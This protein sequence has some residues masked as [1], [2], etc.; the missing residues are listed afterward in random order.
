MN[1]LTRTL[2]GVGTA[3]AVFA[4]SYLVVQAVR[5]DE[6]PADTPLAIPAST[7]QQ[8]QV[9]RPVSFGDPVESADDDA[10]A[11]PSAV[12]GTA[13][14]T[15]PEEAL[16]PGEPTPEILAA[17]AAL[18]SNLGVTTPSVPDTDPSATPSAAPEP[19]SSEPATP[20]SDP[21]AT[22]DDE[23]CPDGAT[24]TLFADTMGD[25][26][27]VWATAD[28]VTMAGMGQSIYCPDVATEEGA[29]RLG[30][31]TT[32]PAAVTITYWPQSD[33]TAIREVFMDET[34]NYG[35]DGAGQCG[36]TGVLE[37]GDY[38]ATAI[39]I[40]AD[41]EISPISTFS[42]DYRGRPIEPPMRVVPLGTN[43]LWVGVGHG[44]YQTALIETVPLTD[45]ETGSCA[46]VD[47]GYVAVHSAARRYHS[48]AASPQAMENLN[49]APEFNR[50]T[51]RLFYIPEGTSVGVCGLTLNDVDTPWDLFAADR[52]QY[53]T[54]AAPDALTAIVSVRTVATFHGGTATFTATGQTGAGCG[55]PMQVT[56]AEPAEVRGHTRTIFDQ[57]IC[58]IS[59]QN[60][61][62]VV[63]T[64]YQ[65]EGTAAEGRSGATF[66]VNSHNCTGTCTPP[67]ME[68][69]LVRLPGLGLDECAA[70]DSDCD[71]RRVLNA[72]A[73][74]DVNWVAEGDGAREAWGIGGTSETRP[75]DAVPER[76]QVD[77]E[78]VTAAFGT[79][80]FDAVASTTIKF[81]RKVDYT[82]DAI[83]SCFTNGA[84]S[85]RK[86]GT[87]SVASGGVSIASIR[88]EGLC[89][90][91]RYT[92]VLRATDADGH[93]VIVAH[94]GT[95]GVSQDVDWWEETVMPQRHINVTSTITVEKLRYPTATWLVD[96]PEV[97]IDGVR[98]NSRYDDGWAI[99]LPPSTRSA[100]TNP[101]SNL[102]P[103][104]REYAADPVI[105][106][107]SDIFTVPATSCR[108]GSQSTWR[109]QDPAQVI[110][111][112]VLLGGTTLTGFVTYQGTDRSGAY[113]NETFRY[114][115]HLRGELVD[116]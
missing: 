60:V 50:M 115:I 98:V 14:V 45:G 95:P 5:S 57:E 104:T 59:G 97:Q 15:V 29:L 32:E 74:V 110:P 35:D 24:V 66:Y 77:L 100:S 85:S 36:V 4:T 54:A 112:S 94:P 40:S 65:D 21:C 82:I 6:I 17:A 81:D 22:G 19:S 49:V 56:I 7:V 33:P 11:Q 103:V 12:V 39:A 42:F 44:A 114:T 96:T 46:S 8:A 102:V 70:D 62:L 64:T 92:Y 55:T 30:S 111:H 51:S 113:I 83:G 26:L 107:H 61:R 72:T 99:C 37:E 63:N 47:T 23:A 53:A 69:Y 16:E 20:A 2:I 108:F 78:P 106:V 84:T 101:G 86:S 91:S 87:S 58:R 76:P 73:L 25:P 10:T 9:L 13:N 27:E 68:T 109:D 93:T 34:R 3:V 75:D 18:D 52:V 71:T 88:L 79:S 89:P 80:M 41:G 31:V 38:D 105:M 43:F 116:E 48:V 28:P 1:T 67:P 90:G